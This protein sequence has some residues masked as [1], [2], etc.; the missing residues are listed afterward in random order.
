[1]RDIKTKMQGDKERWKQETKDHEEKVLRVQSHIFS[2]YI[3]IGRARYIFLDA[4]ALIPD[5]PPDVTFLL[6]PLCSS[7]LLSNR[8]QQ[9]FLF[10]NSSDQEQKAAPP[11]LF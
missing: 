1:M 4:P 3:H 11:D 7:V 2:I 8:D 9:H 5:V 6:R 10:L